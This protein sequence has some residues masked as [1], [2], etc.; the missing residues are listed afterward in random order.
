M[1][2]KALIGV[3]L[4]V[5]GAATYQ[6]SEWWERAYATYISSQTSPDGC[7]R[8]DTYKA[9][10]VLPS[11]LHRIPDPDPE[12]RNDLG[13]DWDGAFFKRAYEVS[14]GD[15]LGETVVFDA[16]ASFNMMFWN[17]SK[18]AGRRIVLANGFPMVD[19][20]RC[21]DKATLAKLEAFY[22]KER[23]E[24]RPIQERWERDRERDREEERLREQNQPDERQASGAAASP[25]GGGRLAGR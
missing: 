8:V 16:S 18:E 11:F 21:A 20:D 5:A 23:E 4:V 14:T 17:D 9:F 7:L 13:R 15:F 3:I 12:N 24:F 1:D 25:P 6:A 2:I 22:E 19:T 10:W